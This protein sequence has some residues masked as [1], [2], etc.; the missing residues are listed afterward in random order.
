MIQIKWKIT[1]DQAGNC[2]YS[3]NSKLYFFPLKSNCIYFGKK[4]DFLY[5]MKNVGHSWSWTAK[6]TK[7]SIYMKR[8]YHL[9]FFFSEKWLYPHSNSQSKRSKDSSNTIHAN[10]QINYS[11]TC[12]YTLFIQLILWDLVVSW[13]SN[14]IKIQVLDLRERLLCQVTTGR[15]GACVQ[16]QDSMPPIH[17]VIYSFYV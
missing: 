8:Y 5:S 1:V 6:Y 15:L 4:G 13:Q 2:S 7:Y 17:K 10:K 11:R 12:L 9:L 14:H 3:Y 16:W